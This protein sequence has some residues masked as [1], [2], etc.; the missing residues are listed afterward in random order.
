[1]ISDFNPN[2]IAPASIIIRM[3]NEEATTI[4]AEVG[5][6][7]FD[8]LLSLFPSLTVGVVVVVPLVKLDA[9]VAV[10]SELV[11]VVGLVI[12]AVTCS[13]HNPPAS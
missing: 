1:M 11:V 2:V 12:V 7:V 4:P 6:G 5:G 9:V 13:P 10:V 8:S 3:I